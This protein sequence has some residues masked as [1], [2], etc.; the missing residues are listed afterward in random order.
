VYEGRALR[1]Q[2]RDINP[3]KGNWK[4][5]RGRGRF[6]QHNFNSHRRY[7]YRPF[8]S[9]QVNPTHGG[10]SGYSPETNDGQSTVASVSE[11]P[12][13]SRGSTSSTPNMGREADKFREWYDGLESAHTPSLSGSS[14]SVTCASYNTPPYPLMHN[15]PYM[16]TPWMQSYVPNGPYPL[17]YYPGYTLYPP[18]QQP[19]MPP[20]SSD[21]NV[22]P[23]AVW[24]S[25][26]YGV[27]FVPYFLG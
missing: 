2:L 12:Q 8:I 23:L 7:N 22:G 1:V 20:T 5:G 9:G 27:S 6:L 4:F 21:A 16:P 15:A 11:T 3:P 26:V 25:G 14:A 13:Q 24:P 10:G 18:Q 19:V 17:P